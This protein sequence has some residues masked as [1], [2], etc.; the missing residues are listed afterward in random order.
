MCGRV[1]AAICHALESCSY[2]AGGIIGRQGTQGD[3]IYVLMRGTV[4]VSAHSHKQPHIERDLGQIQHGE[5]FGSVSV[6]LSR[7]RERSYR[8]LEFSNCAQLRKAR[9]EQI[10]DDFP[11]FSKNVTTWTHERQ[12]ELRKKWHKDHDE[13]QT[14]DGEWAGLAASCG[15]LCLEGVEQKQDYK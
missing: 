11:V 6:L 3:R 1:P 7:P 5:M 15:R 8:A 12:A 13:T 10:L 14:P 4:G 9:I 2:L